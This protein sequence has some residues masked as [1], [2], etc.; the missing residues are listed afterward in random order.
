MYE[1]NRGQSPIMAKELGDGPYN[2]IKEG[3]HYGF[4]KSKRKSRT[5]LEI[6]LR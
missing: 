6:S 2:K 1:D 5:V 4:K 3:A